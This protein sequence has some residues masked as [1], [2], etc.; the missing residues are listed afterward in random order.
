MRFILQIPKMRRHFDLDEDKEE[1]I[2]VEKELE[3]KNPIDDFDKAKEVIEKNCKER[4]LSVKFWKEVF[5]E[6]PHF[7]Y[8]S[9]GSE[10]QFPTLFKVATACSDFLLYLMYATLM[11]AIP[12][13][14]YSLVN[15]FLS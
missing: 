9:V 15:Y 4:R 11:L 13:W 14:I 5:D 12:I 3:L 2:K 8:A 1:L 7:A 6:Y 10:L